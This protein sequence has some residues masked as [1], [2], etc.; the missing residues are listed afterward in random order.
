MDAALISEGHMSA[1]VCQEVDVFELV[2]GAAG[3][4]T[5][6]GAPPGA[7]LRA[8]PSGEDREGPRLNSLFLGT[9]PIPPPYP[10]RREDV[11]GNVLSCERFA[12]CGG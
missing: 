8:A 12:P 9:R 11:G 3:G 7:H 1:E 2:G 5:P 6:W 4:D 10:G